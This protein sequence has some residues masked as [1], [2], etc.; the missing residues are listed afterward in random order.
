MLK[1]I[2]SRIDSRLEA[3]KLSAS[4]ASD[5]AGLS[6]DAIRNLKRAVKT[7]R[8]AGVSNTTI[9]ALA[10]ILETNASWLLTGDGS[11]YADSGLNNLPAGNSPMAG[12]S[13]NRNYDRTVF[14]EAFAR[15]DKFENDHGC[16]ISVEDKLDMIDRYYSEILRLKHGK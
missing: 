14:E 15:A 13:N 1:D 12:E 16:K 7:K 6:K 11:V 5:K 8:K 3:V 10:P 2:V 4:A 9:E